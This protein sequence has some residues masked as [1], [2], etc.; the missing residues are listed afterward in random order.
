MENINELEQ[1]R[2]L[3]VS[4]LNRY[5]AYRFDK[6]ENLQT[7]YLEG[8]I[9]NFKISGGHLYFSLKDSQSEISAIMFS[10]NARYLN[11][12]PA[13]GKLVQVV[14]KVSVYEKRGSYS[15]NIKQMIEKGVGILYQ[16]YLDL[17]K[18]LDEEGLFDTKHKLPLPLYP[19]TIG[20][21][22]SKTG[23]AINDILTT[24]NKRYPLA[25]VVL[26][27]SLVQGSDAPLD[28]IKNLDLAYQNKDIDV[29]IIGR[30]GGSFEDL[31]CFN[32]ESLA[33]KLYEAPFPT[34]SAV[35]HEGD[36]TIVDFIASTRAATPTA[37]ATKAV[38]DK[39]EI[40]QDIDY[41]K[42]SLK[43]NLRS[44]L[45]KLEHSFNTLN[46]SYCLAN[47]SKIIGNF[48][49]YYLNLTN[50]L[51]SLSPTLILNNN[52]EKLNVNVN[53]L[54]L[55]LK[56]RVEKEEEKMIFLSGCLNKNYKLLIDG[57]DLII[58]HLNQKMILLNPLNIM[59]KGYSIVKQENKII[60]SIKDIDLKLPVNIQMV[61]GEIKA[62]IID[63]KENE[64]GK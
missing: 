32:D 40:L 7:V 39:Q 8:E 62:N 60:S 46:K 3:S 49:L 15:I 13:D 31:A 23:E 57:I 11:F 24:L 52:I 17:K 44:Y 42:Q 25:K 58:N 35:G 41:L 61:D 21:I 4:A 26:Y 47:F 56:A 59:T 2:F 48:E 37:A 30:G 54:T 28:L 64:D 16:Q 20:V 50:K 38:R 18:K 51:K 63:L 29:L 9:S 55:A 5:L 1:A 53:H 36:Y 45:L 34:I 14:G 27:P 22:T 43:S 10:F 12:T 33:R 19:K 6:D